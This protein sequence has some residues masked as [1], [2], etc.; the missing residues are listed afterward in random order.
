MRLL[1]GV[2]VT[3]DDLVSTFGSSGDR[4]WALEF[5]A[6]NFVMRNRTHIS[7]RREE[8][9]RALPHQLDDVLLDEGRSVS[10]RREDIDK[11][12]YV[13]HGVLSPK[14]C[15]RLIETA[16][17]IGFTHAGL[18]IGNDTYRV[19]LA[20]RNNTR[21]VIDAPKMALELW[22][23]V[24]TLVDP[25]H[26]GSELRGLN[27][28]F[29]VYQYDVGQ[30]FFP[31]VDVR[32]MVPRGETRESFMIYLNDGFEGGAT[33]FF[34]VKEKSSR[35]GEGR[36]RKFDNRVRLSVRAPVGSVV[37]FDHLLLHEGA[38]VTA[39][40]KYAVRSDLIYAPGRRAK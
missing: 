26:E 29:R 33:R 37:V 28:R 40:V 27:D 32:T 5:L 10:V 22:E 35:R 16:R 39:G 19:N 6:E 15:K 14:E 38:E 20:A 30:R 25:Q 13:L 4:V 7:F 23:R 24:K 17:G 31:H 21:V 1:R 36:G 9:F 8:T 18:A 11:G 3:V 2:W 34:E 12:V